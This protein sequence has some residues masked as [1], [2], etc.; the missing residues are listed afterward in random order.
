VQADATRSFMSL[1]SSASVSAETSV[2]QGLPRTAPVSGAAPAGAAT[3]GCL[4]EP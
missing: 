2:D 1:A 3:A 4:A